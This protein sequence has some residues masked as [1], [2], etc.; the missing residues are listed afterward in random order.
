MGHFSPKIE[1]KEC[2]PQFHAFT[3][4]KRLIHSAIF[5]SFD[6]VTFQNCA[7]ITSKSITSH[8]SLEHQSCSVS[9]QPSSAQGRSWR[10]KL[11]KHS[12]MGGM[13]TNS[14]KV[15]GGRFGQGGRLRQA[16]LVMQLCTPLKSHEE[17]IHSDAAT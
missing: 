15:V 5:D 14:E 10:H 2:L 12:H 16:P 13:M 17:T 9:M 8:F 1:I 7:K 4:E 6:I 3:T 11:I